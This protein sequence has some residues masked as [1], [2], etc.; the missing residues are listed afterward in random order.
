MEQVIEIQGLKKSF[1][2]K[3]VLTNINLT[4]KRG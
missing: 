1:N 4:V 2:G 3:E